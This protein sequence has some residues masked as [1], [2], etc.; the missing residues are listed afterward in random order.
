MRRAA[1]RRVKEAPGEDDIS[2]GRLVVGA[3]SPNKQRFGRQVIADL[4][5]AFGDEVANLGAS[6]PAPKFADECAASRASV[7]VLAELPIAS[8]RPVSKATIAEIAAIA[9]EMIS[10]GVRDRTRIL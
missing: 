9:Q 2:S 8:E 3:I 7:L 1:L 6:V 4:L 10:R 5:E